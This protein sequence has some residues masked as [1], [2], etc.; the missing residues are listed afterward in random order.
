MRAK[1]RAL[2]L[3]LFS[4]TLLSACASPQVPYRDESITL[5]EKIDNSDAGKCFPEEF[6]DL[7]ITLSVADKV[8]AEG[9]LD[10][11]GQYFL[12]LLGKGKILE[13]RFIDELK[14][15]NEEA[16]HKEEIRRQAAIKIEQELIVEKEKKARE[17]AASV[18]K[19]SENARTEARHKA[20]KLKTERELQ[21]ASRHTVKRGETLPQIAALPDVYSDASLWPLLYKANRDQISAPGV[22]WPGQVLRIPRNLD[23]SD[24]SEARRFAV[25]RPL[26]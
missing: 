26:R 23:K 14:R 17:L 25:E 2:I 6:N 20:E 11:A 24:F 5:I 15:R 1:Y 10:Q 12:L 16:V 18:A 8:M 7:I 19:K 9:N 22:L 21:L 3:I 13:R 4:F